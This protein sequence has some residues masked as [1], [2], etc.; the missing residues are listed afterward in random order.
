MRNSSPH[1]IRSPSHIVE[2]SKT[3]TIFPDPERFV[4]SASFH[5]PTL[6]HMS[7]LHLPSCFLPDAIDTHSDGSL[8]TPS[9]L[10]F[11]SLVQ[12]ITTGCGVLSTNQASLPFEGS[13]SNS[14]NI[15][16]APQVGQQVFR[17]LTSASC[18]CSS[19][20]HPCIP[21]QACPTK[22][23]QQTGVK[24]L[25]FLA[26]FKNLKLTVRRNPINPILLLK[27]RRH[28]T[29]T[30]STQSR[31]NA[32]KNRYSRPPNGLSTALS[33]SSGATTLATES[34]KPDDHEHIDSWIDLSNTSLGT[35]SVL[36]S[37]KIR[38]FPEIASSAVCSAGIFR[39]LEKSEPSPGRSPFLTSPPLFRSES[40]DSNCSYF[41]NDPNI[42]GSHSVCMLTQARSFIHTDTE[43]GPEWIMPGGWS[44]SL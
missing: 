26:S 9:P 32:A 13:S 1:E 20:C 35:P 40:H 27:K 39:R 6:A 19:A 5:L 33:N 8:S 7:S 37:N 23:R 41:L 28:S 22:R 34:H 44:F 14:S 30:Q 24:F 11:A 21:C 16:R 10:Y 15:S 42:S 12:S 36:Q 2:D 17:S 18:Q 4:E 43:E 3:T 29:C 31:A 25:N 38:D